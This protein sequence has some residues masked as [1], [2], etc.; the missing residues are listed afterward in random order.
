MPLP[1][2][3]GDI[4]AYMACESRA[5]RDDQGRIQYKTAYEGHL[6]YTDTEN[7]E[8]LERSWKRLKK[9][10]S[11]VREKFF[12]T[13]ALTAVKSDVNFRDS[14]YSEYKANRRK[15]LDKTNPFVPILRERA[16]E[17]G[18]AVEA[19]GREADDLLCMWAHQAMAANE[20]YIIVSIDKDLNCIP[21]PHFNPNKGTL[22]DVSADD[23]SRFFYTQLLTGDS[24]DNI[25]GVPGVGPIKAEK[26]LK[27]ADGEDEYQL[28]VAS[29]YQDAFGDGWHG[30]LLS[31]GKMLYLQKHEDDFFN[32]NGWTLP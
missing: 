11:E 28:V 9:L 22:Y 29:T 5:V 20:P 27:D 32:L 4:Y 16:V 14:I 23:A 3:D 2:I 26:L 24:T 31:N 25:P 13:H 6:T 19:I 7:E 1:L 30:Q 15:T 8:Y 10:L 17:V 18:I 12:A 21:G